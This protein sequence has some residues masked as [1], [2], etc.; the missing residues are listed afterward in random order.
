VRHAFIWIDRLRKAG[1]LEAQ[2]EIPICGC[3]GRPR[4]APSGIL[5][6]WVP[7]Q[8]HP[9]M[10]KGSAYFL[11]GGASLIIR[12]LY[13]KNGSANQDL[14]QVGLYFSKEPVEKRLRSMAVMNK[15]F[16]IPPGNA[17]F[18]VKASV[19]LEKDVE[20]AGVLPHMHLL[21]KSIEITAVRPDG[22]REVLVWV[23]DYDFN[24]Q[25]AYVFKKPVPLPKGTRVEVVAYYDNSEQNPRNPNKPPKAVRWGESATDETC[26][27]YLTYTE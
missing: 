5:G 18:K 2:D 9:R 6:A 10:S 27:A 14:S 24:W 17:A 25:T 20:A 22:T 26:A 8:A 11:P 23:R 3:A 13:R 7:G 15:T 1:R 21:G 4:I 12:V 16:E 19:T